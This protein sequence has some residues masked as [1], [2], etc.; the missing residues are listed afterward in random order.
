VSVLALRLAGPLQ[1]WG[2]SSVYQSRE[3]GR[4][5]SK[6]G[7]VG[8]LAAALGRQRSADISDLAALPMAVRCDRPGAVL[9]DFQ[10]VDYGKAAPQVTTRYYLSGAAFLA[11]MEGDPGFLHQLG[12]AVRAPHWALY[13]GR[14]SC[15]PAGPVLMGVT[16]ESMDEALESLPYLGRTDGAARGS[17]RLDVVRDARRGEHATGFERD[18]PLTFHPD[19]ARYAGRPTVQTTV[20]VSWGER[21]AVH[22]PFTAL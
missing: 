13:L 12:L 3:S 18:L 16:D 10:T 20:T 14:R 6:S 21:A 9:R 2:T 17:M 4:V 11:V 8:L 5:P 1:A 15:P 19:R 22:D 7:V